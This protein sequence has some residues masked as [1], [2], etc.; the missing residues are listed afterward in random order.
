M[1][2][3]RGTAD[4]CAPEPPSTTCNT[5]EPSGRERSGFEPLAEP[6]HHKASHYPALELMAETRLCLREIFFSM[7]ARMGYLQTWGARLRSG[8]VGTWLDGHWMGRLE[9]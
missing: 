8:L 6:I 4:G 7:V 2:N 9:R 1:H 5:T 3:E